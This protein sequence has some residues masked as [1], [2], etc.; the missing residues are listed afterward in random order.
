MSPVK[1]SSIL[2]NELTRRSAI[3][4]A[5]GASL[6]ATKVAAAQSTPSASPAAT[7]AL[8]GTPGG[9]LRFGVVGD[10][11]NLDPHLNVL[12]AAA[13]IFDLVYEGLVHEDKDLVPQGLLAESWTVS[14]DQKTYTFTLRSGV[15][16]HNGR[17]LVADDVVY[18]YERV[19]NPDTGSP[20]VSY[21]GGIAKVEAPDDTTVVISL[22]APDASLL[23][24]LCRRGMTIVPKEEVEKNGDLSQ[25]MVGTG[26][27]AFREYVP[28]STVTL[29]KNAQYWIEGLP[30]LDGLDIQIIPDDTSRTTA[31]V[32]NTV[33]LIE[34]VPAK[35][36]DTLKQTPDVVLTG[37][38]SSNLRWFVFNLRRAP[39]DN[40]ALRQ[41]IASGI[42]RQTIVDTAMFGYGT[43]LLGMYP[44]SY[45]AGYEGEIP[46][47]DPD[48]AKAEI[49]EIGIPEGTKPGILTWAQYDFL[50]AT[51]VVVQEQLRSMGIESG[52]EPEQNAT[53]LDR[54]FPGEFD[55]AVMGAGGYIDPND[56]MQQSLG[57][58]GPAN[59][60][61]YSNPELDELMREGLEEQ[62]QEKRAAIYQQCQQIIIDDAPWIMLY[63]SNTFEGMRSNVK[64]FVHYTSQS[65]HSL[66]ETWLES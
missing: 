32:S 23:S 28:N 24:K 3:G 21:T 8:T 33:D 1:R 37:S 7:P 40:K 25:V 61:G 66:R 38:E 48:G 57:T 64:G 45:W 54:Y 46:A 47:P 65:F 39:W 55:L 43:P 56:F 29:D 50:S 49:A 53:Y 20:W 35:D 9:R 2:T 62:D 58:D 51:S 26:P 22:E 44:A 12:D 17:E 42:D 4:A 6:V 5:V 27:F 52:I 34:T 30:Y 14:E 60:A 13:L 41:A 59:A 10:P 36:I 63:T 16:F 19:M 31:L 11:S 15:M 18:S